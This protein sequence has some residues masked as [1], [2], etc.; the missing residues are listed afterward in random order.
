MSQN[1]LTSGRFFRT[2]LFRGA[3]LLAVLV[4]GYFIFDAGGF[5]WC[6]RRYSDQAKLGPQQITK[7]VN[8]HEAIVVLTGDHARIP[9]ALE[10]LRLRGT[11]WLIIS[12]TGKGTTLLDLINQQ[13]DSAVNI[14]ENWKKIIV[15]SHSASTIEN[16]EES[17]SLLRQKGIEDVILVTSEYH[18]C[19]ALQ[20]F[21]DV[22]PEFTYVP[23][24]V[25]SNISEIEFPPTPAMLDAL[26][27]LWVEYW[28][29]FV[30]SHYVSYQTEPHQK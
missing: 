26:W 20:V 23:Y 8:A 17:R 16:A 22:A 24:P 25:A 3:L 14:H 15:E 9:K 11:P 1:T 30:F 13:G 4:F 19:R 6:C 18:M 29:H 7:P 27:K 5:V 21:R 2:P 28:K 12:G 10:L